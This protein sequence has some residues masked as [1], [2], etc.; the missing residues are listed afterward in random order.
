MGG[1]GKSRL[2]VESAK[3]IAKSYWGRF[4]DGIFFV[5]LVSVTNGDDFAGILTTL[6]DLKLSGNRPALPQL[7]DYIV[8]HEM[9]LIFDNFEQLLGEKTILDFV[10]GLVKT[11]TS[12]RLLLTSRHALQLAREHVVK[13][14]GLAFPMA[15][16][17]SVDSYESKDLFLDRVERLL[18]ERLI[19][20]NA[21]IWQIAHA[22]DGIPIALELAAGMTLHKTPSQIATA[23]SQDIG[24][25][26][27]TMRDVPRRQRSIRAVFNQSWGLL[28]L[29]EQQALAQLAVFPSTFAGKAANTIA[30]TS[31][32][33]LRSLESKSLLRQEGKGVFALHPL[34]RTFAR[35]H[36]ADPNT[37]YQRHAH[38]YLNW[39]TNITEAI[40]G[41]KQVAMLKE[42]AQT[43]DNV[44]LAWQTG[45]QNGDL[46]AI[47]GGI[48]S[49]YHFFT[50]RSNNVG[51]ELF[52]RQAAEAI[53][54][55]LSPLDSLDDASALT[56]LRLWGRRG[57]FLFLLGKFAEART[58][59][60][61][62]QQGFRQRHAPE[63]LAHVLRDEGAV[64]YRTG[65]F[66]QA[67]T[68]LQE[69]FALGYQHENS[70]Q[71]AGTLAYLGNNARSLGDYEAAKKHLLEA[72]QVLQLDPHPFLQATVANDL[73]LIARA[74]GDLDIAK[75][76]Y[77]EAV[78]LFTELG[79]NLRVG[80]GANNLGSVAHQQGDCD[81]AH[82]FARQAIQSFEEGSF[83]HILPYPFS[84]LGRMARDEGAYDKAMAQFQKA[85]KI[86]DE[87]G[88]VPKVLDVLFEMTTV[89]QE[90]GELPQ[91][92]SILAFLQTQTKLH[93]ETRQEVD[94][95]LAEI[96]EKGDLDTA[97]TVYAGNS[98]AEVVFAVQRKLT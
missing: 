66:H 44:Q 73:G 53:E 22:V 33:V 98:L 37:T 92:V 91:A 27:T 10:R 86:A 36:L 40:E 50:G 94:K 49:V 43:F 29:A 4:L 39:L 6:F 93:N 31:L 8:E 96:L 72:K 57:W 63:D 90:R 56:L 32:A 71:I 47:D 23:I 54:T 19:G 60:Q 82:I 88:T 78:A 35:E 74:E 48:S 83:H 25:L 75:T 70:R 81:T 62:C 7:H 51:G 3:R 87:A 20:E 52:F 13:V 38:Y 21:G 97:K 41:A 9:L 46:T 65:E 85:L 84:L 18:G 12:T 45:I 34:I 69:S 5:N 15:L 80:I 64:C 2:A 14:N 79:D 17:S 58:L 77:E 89:W 42:V 55:Y 95:L 59:L 11:E 76:Y 1:S 67:Q 26:A 28:P 61:A 24:N 16:P 30:N 68:L